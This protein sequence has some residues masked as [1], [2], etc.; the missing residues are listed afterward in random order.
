[1]TAARSGGAGAPGGHPRGRLDDVIH[2][3]VR[4]SVTA[5]LAAVDEAEF[6]V[7]RDAVE[8]TDSAL[9]KQVAVLEEAGYV[10]VRKGFVGK[11]PR[12]HLS[13]TG[14]GRD[15]FARHV[16]ALRDIAATGLPGSPP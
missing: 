7:V 4:F 15:A 2:A 3:P 8:I 1:M 6:K 16:R 13:L 12:T 14:A 9:S 5:A 11:R 10:K